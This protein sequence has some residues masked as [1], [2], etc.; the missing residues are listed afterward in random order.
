MNEWLLWTW[1][2]PITVCVMPICIYTMYFLQ[3]VPGHYGY[4]GS[5][6]L[7]NMCMKGLSLEFAKATDTNRVA[8]ALNP[9]WMKVG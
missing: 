8:I 1:C 9:G 6:A 2:S 5:K 7:M 3:T 4:T